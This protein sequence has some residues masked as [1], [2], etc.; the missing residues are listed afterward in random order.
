MGRKLLLAGVLLA[1]TSGPV[2]VGLAR[3]GQITAQPAKEGPYLFFTIDVPGSS[4]TTAR[5]VNNLGQIAG[6]FVDGRGTHGFLYNNEKF[7]AVD[8]P[9]SAWTIATGINNAGQIVG[10]YGPGGEKGNHGFLFSNGAF[11]SLDFPGSLDTVAYSINNKSQ[12]VG[13]F[14]GSD[15]LRH[16]FRL[17]GGAYA[18]IE[19]PESRAGAAQ[20]IN[21]AGQIVGLAGIG[22][23]ATG[24]LYDGSSYSRVLK[25]DNIFTDV[26]GLNNLGDLVGQEGG[27]Q[28]PFRGFIR[29]GARSSL[30][31][32]PSGPVSWN[33][34][35]I[36]DLGQIVG[37]FSNRDGRSH[38]YFASP[39]TLGGS[40]VGGA[41][42]PTIRLTDLSG[43]PAVSGAAGPAAQPATAA[44]PGPA[45][46]RG[47]FGDRRG[48]DLVSVALNRV[49]NGIGTAIGFT[50]SANT[51]RMRHLTSARTIA[52]GAVKQADA[53][54]AFMQANPAAANIAPLPQP[55]KASQLILAD[56][57]QGIDP[58]LEGTFNILNTALGALAASPGGG[59]GG[60]RE[61]LS[62][63]INSIAAEL[64]AAFEA[65]R[66]FN[67]P[68]RGRGGR[69]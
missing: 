59:I 33:A 61:K 39:K 34:L 69:G 7:T 68:G 29:N 23:A 43:A 40:A 37:E 48:L 64:V 15:G 45:G 28:A 54:L 8:V 67:L 26:R 18:L 1:A 42:Q 49:A 51:D 65:S 20:G 9:G 13:S 47:D 16:G 55:S 2:L 58:G 57:L 38:G 6:S 19:V 25:S 10:G 12:I 50:N 60:L 46:A 30:I 63:D 52:E 4:A 22:G 44:P 62:A 5:A 36:N 3:A 21:D 32:L 66:V 17:S 53:A 31:E 35:G 56:N 27:P 41:G 14:L 24:F 11:S